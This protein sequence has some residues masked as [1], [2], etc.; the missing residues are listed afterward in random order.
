LTKLNRELVDA[1][2]DVEDI[3]IMEAAELASRLLLKKNTKLGKLSE[4]KCP[5]FLLSTATVTAHRDRAAVL[6]ERRL[7]GTGQQHFGGVSSV[8]NRSMFTYSADYRVGLQND[9]H[10]SIRKWPWPQQQQ[11]AGYAKFKATFSQPQRNCCCSG[12]SVKVV[13]RNYLTFSATVRFE[14][15]KRE[16]FK[17]SDFLHIGIFEWRLV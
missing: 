1:A 9:R 10:F 4:W 3:V 16:K 15:V 8:R 12:T 7:A 14:N 17:F 6:M 11:N 2:D 5:L 13:A